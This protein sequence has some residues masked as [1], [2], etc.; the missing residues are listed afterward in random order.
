MINLRLEKAIVE[1]FDKVAKLHSRDRSKELKSL[2]LEDI[3]TVY[4]DFV[5]P[6]P[7]KD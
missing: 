1:A 6:E 2:M 4:P 7:S 3:H 5:E